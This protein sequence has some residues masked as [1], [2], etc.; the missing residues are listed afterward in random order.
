[1]SPLKITSY[2]TSRIYTFKI[3]NIAE[4][5]SKTFQLRISLGKYKKLLKLKE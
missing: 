5:K 4:S 2:S 3:S 1:M